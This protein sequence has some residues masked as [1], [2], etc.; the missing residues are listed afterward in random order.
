MTRHRFLNAL[1]FA[2]VAALGLPLFV[3]VAQNI[4]GTIGA[5]GLYATLAIA[6]HAALFAPS[7]RTG[8]ASLV[9]VLLGGFLIEWLV[10]HGRGFAGLSTLIF[11]L[12]V[13]LA[14]T[15]AGI[16]RAHVGLR[17][18]IVEVVVGAMAIGLLGLFAGSGFVSWS[19]ACWA[20]FLAQAMFHLLPRHAVR[21]SSG[22]AGDGF[23]RAAARLDSLLAEAES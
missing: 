14:L 1:G 8:L 19:M 23:A 10:P 17:A 5:L 7:P 11:G 4:L 13:L 21:D 15:R 9:V 2:A 12:T 6:A 22:D 20:Y 16:Q 3:V 18:P